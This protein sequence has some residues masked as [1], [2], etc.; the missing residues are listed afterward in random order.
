MLVILLWAITVFGS[1]WREWSKGIYLL[2]AIFM[3]GACLWSAIW[4]L[5]MCHYMYLYPVIWFASVPFVKVLC[6]TMIA[7]SSAWIMQRQPEQLAGGFT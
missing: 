6:S 4:F 2:F 7:A 3:W 5:R 1:G